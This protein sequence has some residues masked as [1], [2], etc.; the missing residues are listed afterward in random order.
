MKP[1]DSRNDGE[2]EETTMSHI[3]ALTPCPSFPSTLFS[4]VSWEEICGTQDSVAELDEGLTQL[5][6]TSV[7]VHMLHSR[8]PGGLRLFFF[9]VN[10]RTRLASTSPSESLVQNNIVYRTIV[11]FNV[12]NVST[13]F[14]GTFPMFASTVSETSLKLCDTLLT[15]LHNCYKRRFLRNVIS[16]PLGRSLQTP[17]PCQRSYYMYTFIEKWVIIVY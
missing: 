14:S 9:T 7:M 11:I 10:L 13:K 3:P 15:M 6:P 12:G 2:I 17:S 16:P 4:D 5:D 1:I 8:L